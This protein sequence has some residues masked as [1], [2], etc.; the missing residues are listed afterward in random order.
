MVGQAVS[1]SC[2][3]D[4][5]MFALLVREDW[6]WR[7]RVTWYVLALVEKPPAHLGRE[8]GG[9]NACWVG[10][11]TGDRRYSKPYWR[12]AKG[13]HWSS[14]RF[15]FFF[16]W[17]LSPPKSRWQRSVS[18]FYCRP[19]TMITG[20]QGSSSFDL[21]KPR[22]ALQLITRCSPGTVDRRCQSSRSEED[23]AQAENKPGTH[24]HAHLPLD[25]IPSV[26]RASPLSFHPTTPRLS[27]LPTPLL[28]T[29]PALF[30]EKN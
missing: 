27:V 2:D 17:G 28:L 12:R 23:G 8:D 15:F 10:V 22:I 14:R 4:M 30:I 6:V 26:H 9:V 24:A 11:S 1:L 21:H 7:N 29:S 18:Y 19:A 20:V 25:P 3:T 5:C 16:F 13:Q